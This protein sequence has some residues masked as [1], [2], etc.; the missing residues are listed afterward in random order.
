MIKNECNAMQ[1]DAMQCNE[2]NREIRRE[3]LEERRREE[4][5][6]AEANRLRAKQFGAED[7]A[8]A[9]KKK[10][11]DEANHK[12]MLEEM[13][14]RE[15]ERHEGMHTRLVTQRQ[16]SKA[17][18]RD[19]VAAE[20]LKDVGFDTC[21]VFVNMVGTEADSNVV[22]GV[23]G[24]RGGGRGGRGRVAAEVNGRVPLEEVSLSSTTRE[25]CVA[26]GRACGTSP[27]GMRL[28]LQGQ[29][30]EGGAAEDMRR[31]GGEDMPTPSLLDYVKS[32]GALVQ[33]QRGKSRVLEVCVTAIVNAYGTAPQRKS[34]ILK[35]PS[36][37]LKI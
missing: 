1:C 22:G 12:A 37:G 25:I 17:A 26:A 3:R 34:R 19:S 5:E 15:K 9:A 8:A 24:G 7:A 11:E 23:G 10:A 14:R 27:D 21:K 20:W 29:I 13:R 32:A 16:K 18:Y 30:F 6:L 35:V 36:E 2:T 33:G 4:A 28:V 31:P